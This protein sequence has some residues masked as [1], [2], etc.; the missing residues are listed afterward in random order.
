VGALAAVVAVVLATVVSDIGGGR[1]AAA[2]TTTMTPVADAAVN[3][4]T[5]TTRY[6]TNAQLIADASPVNQ[7]FLR[8]DLRGVTGTVQSAT[9][10]L[11]VTD[12]SNGGSPAGGTV[13]SSTNTTWS[14][15]TVPGTRA[16]PSTAPR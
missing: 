13:A 9:L 3:Q 5:P 11:H 6:G 14:E 1:T 16:R 10:R 15:S 4:S 7:S 12:I 8:F 2:A